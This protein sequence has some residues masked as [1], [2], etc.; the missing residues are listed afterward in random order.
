MEAEKLLKSFEETIAVL[1]ENRS[2]VPVVVEA[3]DFLN[4]LGRIVADPTDE[5]VKEV[6]EIMKGLR[7]QIKPLKEYAPSID[8]TM[9]L[10]RRWTEEEFMTRTLVVEDRIEMEPIEAEGFILDIG[11]GG[12][13]I[14]GKLNGRDVV[15]I[16]LSSEELEETE[17]D[18]LKIVMDATDL[19][20][21]PST[22][23]AATSFFT[24]LYVDRERQEKVFSEVHR[25]LRDGGKFLIWDVRIPDEAEG[26]PFFLVQL[27]VSL[28]DEA[29]TTGYGVKMAFQD[30]DR[31]KDLAARTG[32]EIA[33]E[34][35]RND[36]FHLELVKT[37]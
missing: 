2:Q 31:F 35:S 32:F 26:K 5:N 25:V 33:R 27:E 1:E 30:M 4:R 9:S 10:L 23:A 11:G 15:A 8:E 6:I 36:L 7:P 19:R 29:V 37:S 17:N 20:F 18:A 24:L 13:G 3:I 16:D 34:W 22:F 12:E 21:V 28:P 14:I